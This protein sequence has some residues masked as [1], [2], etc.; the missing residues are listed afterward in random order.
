[1]DNKASETAEAWQ[2]VF[3][4]SQVAVKQEMDEPRIQAGFARLLSSGL[5][6]WP[7]PSHIF[8]L[9]PPR[10]P[11]E[12]LEHTPPASEEVNRDGLERFRLIVGGIAKDKSTTGDDHHNER[13]RKQG[14]NKQKK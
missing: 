4:L 5:K 3:K 8:D 12:R 11:Q 10:P 9:M 13:Q 1:M 7:S 6:E 2:V 14:N